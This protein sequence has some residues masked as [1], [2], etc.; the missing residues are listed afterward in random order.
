MRSLEFGRPLLR[1]TNTGVTAI[2]NADGTIAEQLP[3]FSDAV[4]KRP[5]DLVKGYTPYSQYGDWP[6]YL[7]SL[8]L[9]GW[10]VMAHRYSTKPQ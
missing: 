10:L 9:F 8:A 3:Q 6:L 5:V 1:A 2:V 7:L 4:L